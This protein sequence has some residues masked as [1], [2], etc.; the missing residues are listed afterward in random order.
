MA[1]KSP[2]E[3]FVML[4][5]DLRHREERT[6]EILQEMSEAAKEQD[7]KEALESRV[8]LKSQIISSLDRCFKLIGEQPVKVTDRMHDIFLEDFRRELGEIQ[9]PVARRLYI[10][11]KLKHLTHLRIGEYAA[12]TAM[13]DMTGHFAV[14]VLLES[15]MADKLAFAERTRRLIRRYVESEIE[16]RMAA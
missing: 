3:V 12:L 16:A 7:V 13:A 8:F 4:L 10:L 9:S 5:S 11:A 15:C 2:K 1:V 6:T 14:G